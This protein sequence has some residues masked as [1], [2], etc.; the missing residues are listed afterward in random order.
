MVCLLM[1]SITNTIIMDKRCQMLEVDNE[2]CMEVKSRM[3]WVFALVIVGY[4]LLSL[5]SWR[6]RTYKPATASS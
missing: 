1:P 3:T 6:A 5:V 4:F 2:Q